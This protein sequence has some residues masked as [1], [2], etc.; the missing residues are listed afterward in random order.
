MIS[1]ILVNLLIIPMSMLIIPMSVYNQ[2]LQA[3]IW[4]KLKPSCDFIFHFIIYEMYT[5]LKHKEKGRLIWNEMKYM[6]P[7]NCFM[8]GFNK[9]SSEQVSQREPFVSLEKPL[10]NGCLNLYHLTSQ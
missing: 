8:V 5:C 10:K 2:T 4:F 7:G 1:C 3:F 9:D 6:N